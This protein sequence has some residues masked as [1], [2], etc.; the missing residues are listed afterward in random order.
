[1]HLSIAIVFLIGAI[2]ATEVLC[3]AAE[4]AAKLRTWFERT[5]KRLEKGQ[6][7]QQN[8]HFIDHTIDRTVTTHMSRI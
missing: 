4:G 1:M 8:R 3:D 2:V 5:V 6:T 7:L